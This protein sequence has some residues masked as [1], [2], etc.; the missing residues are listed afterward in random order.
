VNGETAVA[1]GFWPD[2][3]AVTIV[4][5]EDFTRDSSKLNHKLDDKDH[6]A[7]QILDQRAETVEQRC[8][9]AEQRAETAEHKYDI[10]KK[11]LEDVLGM[12]DP[13]THA[14]VVQR[15]NT[16]LK[17]L[18]LKSTAPQE[19]GVELSTTMVSHLSAVPN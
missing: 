18:R 10:L 2:G 17:E 14:A 6:K 4:S 8:E 15:I 11:L 19:Q 16:V 7:A 13:E 3:F 1:D 5:Y 12:L 9:T